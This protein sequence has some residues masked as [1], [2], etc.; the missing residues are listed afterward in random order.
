MGVRG[1]QVIRTARSGG[2]PVPLDKERTM[3]HT[4]TIGKLRGLR[5]ISTEGG[6][7]TMAAEDQR[8]SMRK[9]L[10]PND[11]HSVPAAA[12]TEVKLDIA[13][14]LNPLASALLIYPDFRTAPALSTGALA[15]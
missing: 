9:M 3:A 1:C 12:M 7:F 5:Q 4:L 2:C 11:P 6:I 14:A 10:N 8:G 13:R 15:G